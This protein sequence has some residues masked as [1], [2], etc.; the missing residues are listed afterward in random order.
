M[1]HTHA[2]SNLIS[3]LCTELENPLTREEVERPKGSARHNISRHN[4]TSLTNKK[5]SFRTAQRTSH[6]SDSFA[7]ELF[8]P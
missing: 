8:K 2:P 4:L 7:T 3:V 5:L 1:W 6:Q